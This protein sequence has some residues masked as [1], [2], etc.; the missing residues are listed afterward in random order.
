MTIR[1]YIEG[2]IVGR[3]PRAIALGALRTPYKLN[4]VHE[5]KALEC[6][7][8]AGAFGVPSHAWDSAQAKH[9]FAHKKRER[10]SRTPKKT[11]AQKVPVSLALSSATDLLEPVTM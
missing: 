7:S 5:G 6:A 8:H 3:V 11:A 10:G 4:S 1:E 2:N 9:S